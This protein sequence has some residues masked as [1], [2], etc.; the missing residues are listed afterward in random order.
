[1]ETPEPQDCR[2][3]KGRL[4]KLK[5]INAGRQEGG[6]DPSEEAVKK[7]TVTEIGYQ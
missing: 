5:V 3:V 4:A 2:A 6:W 1:M 7:D